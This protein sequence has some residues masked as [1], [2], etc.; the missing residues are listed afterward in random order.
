[1]EKKAEQHVYEKM[2]QVR[3]RGMKDPH[4]VDDGEIAGPSGEGASYSK[5]PAQFEQTSIIDSKVHPTLKATPHSPPPSRRFRRYSEQ[6]NT[7]SKS[8]KIY[9]ARAHSDMESK[10]KNSQSQRSRAASDPFVQ[11]KPA[12]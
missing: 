1:M 12:W 5:G 4:V 9:H 7:K 6:L 2:L 10:S 11:A 3:I 8:N